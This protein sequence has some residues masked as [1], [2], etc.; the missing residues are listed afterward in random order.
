MLQRNFKKLLMGAAVVAS[1]LA[2]DVP[3]ADAFWGH[4]SGGSSGGYGSWGSS[5]GSSGGSWGSSG[6]SS[7]GYYYGSS[8]GGHHRH[9]RR[10]HHAY[11]AGSYGSWGSSGGSWGSSGGSWGSSGGSYGSWGSSGGYVGGAVITSPQPMGGAPAGGAQQGNYGGTNPPPPYPGDMPRDQGGALDGDLGP[12]GLGPAPNDRLGPADGDLPE[13]GPLPP[14]DDSGAGLYRGRSATLSV[15]VPADAKVFVNG[16]ATTSKG[17]LRR[18]VSNGLQPGFNYAYEVRAEIMRDGQPISETKVVKLQ[19][20]QVSD[21]EFAL[22]ETDAES[23]AAEPVRTSLTLHVPADAKVYLSG[24]ETRGVGETRVFSTTR[25]SP[26][27]Q[28]AKYAVR[29]EVQRNGRTLSQEET[30]DLSGGET[31]EL[32]IAFDAPQVARAGG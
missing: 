29:V 32:T 6:G 20:G 24:K 9:H 3:Q 27:E 28:W 23:I 31:R 15:R 5:G 19:A 22:N 14:R 1:A 4:S 25:L 2:M 30:V 16:L 10:H 21:L 18:Y 26:G 11:Y 7:G 8:G 13:D 17:S 12:D